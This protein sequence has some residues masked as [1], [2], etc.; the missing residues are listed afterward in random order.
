MRRTT[1]KVPVCHPGKTGCLL[2]T[3]RSVTLLSVVAV[4]LACAFQLAITTPDAGAVT[5]Y[6]QIAGVSN[7][8][9][10][11]LDA[12]L[13]SVNP[14]HIHPDIAQLY[15]EWGYRFGIRAD[16]A[17]AQMLL[18]TNYLQY[19]HSCD[20]AN[21]IPGDVHPS[22]NNFAGM[23][24][25]GGGNPGNSFA[26]AELGVIAQYAHLAWYAYPDHL[27]E[28]CNTTYDPRHFGTGHV[29][30]APNLHDLGGRWAVPG[31]T[32]GRDIARLANQIWRWPPAGYAL[33]SFNEVAGVPETELATSY[34]FPWYDS[35][36]AHG[37][38]GNWI[39]VG[40]QGSGVARVQ[41]WI[42]D[43]LVHDPAHPGT[44]YFDIPEGGRITPSFA[45]TMGGPVRVVSTTGQ[46]LI[47][48]QRVLYRDSFTE[49][50][51]M[52]VH[53]LSDSY[54]FTWYDSQPQNG[55]GGNWILVANPGLVT[56]DVEI[57]VGGVV[58]AEYKAS[59]GNAL[60]PGAI[61]TPYFPNLAAGPVLV[62]STNH[63]QLI[64]SQRVVYRNSFNEVMGFPTSL[65]AYDY[66][67]AWYDSEPGNSMGGDWLMVTNRGASPADVDIF[68]GGILRA[69][70]RTAD[71]NPIMPGAMV[72]PT[73]PHLTGGPVRI[74][75]S[76]D[77]P[78]MASQR[79][80]YRESFEEVQ[81]TLPTDLSDTQLFTWYDSTL[82]DYMW[83]D[84]LLVSNL[85][86]GTATVEIYIGESR[87]HDPQNPGNDYFTIP[88]GGT[89][90]PH[91]WN[92]RGGP[93]RIVSTTG[94]QL[95]TS[96]R[97]LYKEGLTRR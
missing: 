97:V 49:V 19:C 42:G 74:I 67:F 69:Q 80:V 71:G 39:L 94:Q 65:L 26:T 91:Y 7:V 41:I 85:G 73:F 14:N 32:Y 93:V 5:E 27:N 70:Y 56:A 58:R 2:T 52:P 33:G 46:P 45:N 34:T 95:L 40:N 68:V 31:T 63:Q 44:P 90:T 54:E 50:P 17:F 75:C 79:V 13:D 24:A 72:A 8:T 11:Q 77:Q 96:Q 51:G 22:Q 83:G 18:E 1:I 29:F 28:Y 10:A 53:R 3:A 35:L 64:A 9:A 89:I 6:D 61:V 12:E 55:M 37:M 25:T 87:M 30:T 66:S 15:V 36:A 81:G 59:L 76:N 82:I 20:P 47:A 88:E 78:I 16:L 84:W 4:M 57:L 62:R 21:Y 38:G 23:G 92:F 48:S 43:V 86:S 60:A